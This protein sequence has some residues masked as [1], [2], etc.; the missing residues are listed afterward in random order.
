MT[1]IKSIIA[2]TKLNAFLFKK[3]CRLLQLQYVV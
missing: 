3:N 1:C 2:Q